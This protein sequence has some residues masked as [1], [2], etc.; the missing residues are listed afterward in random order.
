[1]RHHS[2]AMQVRA[3][4][5]AA[6]AAEREGEDQDRET[7]MLILKMSININTPP[8]HRGLPQ[9]TFLQKHC[10]SFLQ[11]LA[12][13][14]SHSSSRSK[15]HKQRRAIASFSQSHHQFCRLAIHRRIRIKDPAQR[16]LP[17]SFHRRISSSH[18]IQP[19]QTSH[20]LNLHNVSP[21]LNP[22]PGRSS[23]T[24][25]TSA[26]A[27]DFQLWLLATSARIPRSPETQWPP[28]KIHPAST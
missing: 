27:K 11:D 28:S 24:A 20:S 3:E 26:S 8:L 19:T 6:A 12:A 9:Y 25:T 15:I 22:V 14:S 7:K 18:P 10:E 17:R 21:S 5:L 2:T 4:S 13:P 16:L 23:T 1:M